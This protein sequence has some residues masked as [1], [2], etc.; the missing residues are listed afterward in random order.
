MV[1]LFLFRFNG[2][3]IDGLDRFVTVCRDAGESQFM[4]YSM[5]IADTVSQHCGIH[6]ERSGSKCDQYPQQSESHGQTC[7]RS[8]GELQPVEKPMYKY[9]WDLQDRETEPRF[10]GPPAGGRGG[11][12]GGMARGGGYGAGGF[13]GP[14]AGP[15]AGGRQIFVSNVCALTL[16][17]LAD[18]E[19]ISFIDISYSSFLTP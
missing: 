15:G 4:A 18:V 10:T 17:L 5:L 9:S 3:W 7:I 14:G 11:Y 1:Y 13:G 19:E 12:D 6:V 8:R 2:R 16:P